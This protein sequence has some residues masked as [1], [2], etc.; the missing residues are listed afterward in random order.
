[1][2]VGTHNS[3][4]QA[5]EKYLQSE[6]YKTLFSSQASANIIKECLYRDNTCYS[7]KK[8]KKALHYFENKSQKIIAKRKVQYYVKNV[9][10]DANKVTIGFK[11]MEFL[12]EEK[13]GIFIAR[14][15][16]EKGLT[17]EELGSCISN[18]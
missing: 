16:K 10:P 6:T 14:R 12:P 2:I 3:S 18:K 11:F 5:I 1:M 7:Y 17:Q 8:A 4:D 13:I 9:T 15:R